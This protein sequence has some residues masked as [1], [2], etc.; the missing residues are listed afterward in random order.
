MTDQ[1]ILST[2]K[3]NKKSIILLVSIIVIACSISFLIRILPADFGWELNEFDPFFNYRA[4]EFIVENGLIKYFDWHDELSWYPNGRNISANSQVILHSFTAFSYMIFGSGIDLY[5]YVIIFPAIIGS[6]TCIPIFLLGRTI[7]GNTVGLFSSLLFSISI[8]ILVRGQIG[9]FK[10]EPLG[11]FLSTISVYLFLSGIFSKNKKIIFLKMV[12]GGL[13]FT[14][15]L[16]AWG[17][18]YYFLIILSIFIFSFTFVKKPIFSLWAIPIFITTSLLSSLIFER[19][20]IK[21]IF[22]ISGLILLVPTIF[23]VVSFILEKKLNEK[24]SKKLILLVLVSIV[25]IGTTLL[26]INFLYMSLYNQ[27]L[28][29]TGS[30]RYLNAI[31]PFLNT[32]NPL[33]ESI[34]EHAILNLQT[35]FILHSI[36]MIFGSLAIWLMLSETKLKNYMNSGMMIFSLIFGFFGLYI[37]SAFMRLEV[38]ASLSLIILTSI[39]LTYLT[40]SVLTK[41]KKISFKI[42]LFSG[43]IILLLIPLLLPIESTIY[44]IAH[45]PPTI[46]N[47]GSSFPVSTQD[48]NLA[49]EWIKNNTNENSVMVSWW[50]YGYW[51]QTKAERTTYIDNATL[52]VGSIEKIAKIFF[53]EPISAWNSLK[54]MNVEYLIIFVAAEKTPITDSD[55][56]DLYL[57]QGGG[58]ESKKYWIST[59]GGNSPSEFFYADGVTSKP[60][61]WENTLLGKLIPYSSYGFLNPSNPN[62]GSINYVNGYVQVFHKDI[63]FDDS[64]NLPFNLVYSSPTYD[65]PINNQYV[66][67]VFIYELN[68]QYVE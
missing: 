4:T 22:G 64:E 32:S 10:S 54:E 24:L 12:L 62:T 16:S 26:S 48:W 40:K 5:D 1:T 61:F 15:A 53:S 66:V 38:F 7:G 8:P 60:Q 2:N 55:G 44:G 27:Q 58:D 67:G 30:Y 46:L 34:S 11:I 43:T 52:Y 35:S 18:N 28:L 63:K 17:G 3:D 56:N 50:D 31:N 6:L 41:S 68:Q 39:T 14:S 37:S 57:L 65:F 20:S 33:I 13:I 45:T 47:G 25:I 42:I 51:I 9:W 19:L 59:I 49:F 23:F 21:F 36:L 29:E